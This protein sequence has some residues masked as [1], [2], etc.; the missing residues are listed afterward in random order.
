[1]SRF[2]ADDDEIE[3]LVLGFLD[4][5]LPKARWT[6]AAHFATALWLLR[7][8][9]EIVVER[10]MPVFIR[11][12]NESVGGVNSDTEGYHETITQASLLAAGGFL[13]KQPPERALHEIVDALM[14]SPLGD[15]GW[16]LEYWSRDVLFSVAARR[17]WVAPD[18]KPLPAG[19]T[20]G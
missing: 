1:M 6:H 5:S 10:E 16:L 9:P 2:F 12:Y 8:R 19:L 13:G 20:L 15:P 17:G 3:G 14:G 18:L 11:R 7:H 4:R